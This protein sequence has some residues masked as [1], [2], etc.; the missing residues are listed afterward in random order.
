VT[1]AAIPLL[2]SAKFGLRFPVGDQFVI[3]N[4]L[5]TSC[6][7]LITGEAI[8]KVKGS[9]GPCGLLA[10]WTAYLNICFSLCPNFFIHRLERSHQGDRNGRRSIVATSCQR[11]HAK[12]SLSLSRTSFLIRPA[13]HLTAEPVKRDACYLLLRRIQDARSEIRP[14]FSS[15]SAHNSRLVY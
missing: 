3:S 6:V 11:F 14:L 7:D 5:A 1:S 13:S 8:T 9:S 2:A 4:E 12:G 10:H 15:I